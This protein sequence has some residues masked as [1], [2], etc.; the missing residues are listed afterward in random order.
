M[1][2]KKSQLKEAVKAIVRQTLSERASAKETLAEAIVKI[3]T[4]KVPSCRNNPTKLVEVASQL[5]KKRTGK[6]ASLGVL[7]QI[8]NEVAPPGWEGTVKAMKKDKGVENPWALAW[9]MKNKGYKSHKPEPEMN[10]EQ[11]PTLP[12]NKGQYKKV[13]PHAYTTADENE[14]LTIQ[15]DPEVNESDDKWIQK[16]VKHPGRCAHMG[17]AE[18]PV[19]S[20]QYNLA[21]RFKKG[22]IHKANLQ[23]ESGLTSEEDPMGGEEPSPETEPQFGGEEAPEMGMGG[24]EP[25]AFGGEEAP[26]MG[27]GGEE[28]MGGEAPEGGEDEGAHE[29][30]EIKLIKLMGL[31]AKKLEMMH[32]GMPGD[33]APVSLPPEVEEPAGEEEPEVPFKKP[34]EPKKEKSEKPEKEDGESESKPKK[35]KKKKSKKGD[36][37]P[38]EFTKKLA[39]ESA[40]KVQKRSYTTSIDTSYNPKNVQDPE[41]PGT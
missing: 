38:T 23:K 22:D 40:Y 31:C 8:V 10:E 39:K 7:Q 3:V 12:P 28:P 15:S 14:P 5:Y 34:S 11:R 27:M 25:Q 32:Q 35:D 1:K 4:A 17:S 33:E 29:R 20:P 24:E 37:D 2:M 36:E 26:E 13:A 9:S 30:M 41:I 16:A 6:P 21:K 19:G 18:C